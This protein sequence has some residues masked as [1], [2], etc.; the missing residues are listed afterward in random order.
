MGA[1]T[2][3]GILQHALGRPAQAVA[4]YREAIAIEPDRAETYNNLAVALLAIG[5]ADEAVPA[6]EGAARLTGWRD[7]Q[8]LQTLAAARAAAEGG[9]AP[10]PQ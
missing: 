2:N 4:L 5:R 10:S 1:L 6:A 7:A 3:Y 8:V 9:G